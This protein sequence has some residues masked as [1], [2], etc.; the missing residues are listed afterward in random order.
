MHVSLEVDNHALLGVDEDLEQQRCWGG[1]TTSIAASFPLITHALCK[2]P[3]QVFSCTS[4][5]NFFWV[6][7]AQ[8]IGG[9]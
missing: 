2:A 7:F 5:C 3:C 4:A 1:G 6:P 8:G 9:G